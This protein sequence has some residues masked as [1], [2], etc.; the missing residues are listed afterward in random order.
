MCCR[1]QRESGTTHCVTKQTEHKD[2]ADNKYFKFH[3]HRLIFFAG[4][5]FC[6]DWW[7]QKKKSPLSPIT[8]LFLLAY[9]SA[10]SSLRGNIS[11]CYM[12]CL[13]LP[14]E[15]YSNLKQL[16]GWQIVKGRGAKKSRS[17][18]HLR[19]MNNCNAR[20][21]QKG[22]CHSAKVTLSDYAHTGNITG[23]SMPLKWG[24]G[25]LHTQG[26]CQLSTT[27]GNSCVDA[28]LS[29]GCAPSILGR[30]CSIVLPSVPFLFA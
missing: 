23:T 1:N 5:P 19:Q 27:G 13:L 25:G 18:C 22:A 9:N 28:Q 2:E 8:L 6:H 12:G 3:F 16:V 17:R 20:G 10:R 14:R 21:I 29:G 30:V 11:G 7:Q 26:W 4:D 24:G 15:K